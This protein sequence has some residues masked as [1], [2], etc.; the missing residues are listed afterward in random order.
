[1]LP[2]NG[3]L[4][5]HAKSKK[6]LNLINYT[7]L[8]KITFEMCELEFMLAPMVISML[9]SMLA[10]S[11]LYQHAKLK[12]QLNLINYTYLSKITF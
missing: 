6:Q 4:Y 7:C 11:F 5:L 8:S 10:N 2:A 9:P 12:K 1:M 3:F